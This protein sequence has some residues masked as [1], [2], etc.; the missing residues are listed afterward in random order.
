[1]VIQPRQPASTGCTVLA[2]KTRERADGCTAFVS[3]FGKGSEEPYGAGAE[4]GTLKPGLSSVPFNP[5][6]VKW[7]SR[8]N[9]TIVSNAV[10]IAHQE[11]FLLISPFAINRSRLW[12]IRWLNELHW[13]GQ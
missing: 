8:G 12:K 10:L 1:L 13:L 2:H 5:P 9:C 4:I 6:V 11:L 3:G 7:F